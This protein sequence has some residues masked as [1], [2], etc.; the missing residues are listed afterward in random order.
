MSAG[1][2]AAF[3]DGREFAAVDDVL[4]FGGVVDVW[5]YDA[6][7]SAVEGPVNESLMVV[8]YAADGCEAPKVA[9]AGEVS[10]FGCVDPSV[11]A[12]KPDAVHAVGGGDR[13]EGVD[14]VGVG[15]SADDGCDF[16]G[17]DFVFDA[18]G[19]DVH[20]GWRLSCE[21]GSWFESGTSSW[22]FRLDF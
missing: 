15:H 9:G 18:I 16:A 1:V 22:D 13:A 4:G 20:L 14:V 5:H 3:A 7:G 21:L 10:E 19:A 6:L 8:V 2:A 11:F 17:G 12:F